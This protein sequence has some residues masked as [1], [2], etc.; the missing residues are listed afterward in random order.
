MTDQPEIPTSPSKTAITQPN[1][2]LLGNTLHW[3]NTPRPA[4][5]LVIKRPGEDTNAHFNKIIEFLYD[6][7]NV[8]L[9]IELNAKDAL[10]ER[11]TNVEVVDTS[12]IASHATW[13]TLQS[14]HLVISLGGDGTILYAASLFQSKN[15]FCP[16][17]LPFALGS[18]GFLTPIKFD[19]YKEAI[20]R[21]LGFGRARS[22]TIEIHE[23]MQKLK[24][25]EY[26]QDSLTENTPEEEEDIWETD[27]G[28]DPDEENNECT[29][30]P[31][32]R[33]PKLSD[34][35]LFS[36]TE[37]IFV[38]KRTRLFARVHCSLKHQKSNSGEL[39]S[40][41][42]MNSLR[43]DDC[44]SENKRFAL[45]E[46]VIDRGPNHGM[47]HLE[48]YINDI[49]I[50]DIRG[51]GL[52]ISTP[53]GSTGYN[54][55]AGGSLV[56]PSTVAVLITPICPHSLSIRPIVIPPGV[57]LVIKVAEDNR[58][59]PWVSFDGRDA[60]ALQKSQQVSIFLPAKVEEQPGFVVPCI[61]LRDPVDDWFGSLSNCLK[62]NISSFSQK[63]LTG[64]GET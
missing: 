53:T 24:I 51:D 49:L 41:D 7:R 50:E 22:H 45:N 9:Y 63:K 56:H 29:V 39:A 2:K 62:W 17:I 54:M 60:H 15:T 26:V 10:G 61:C 34:N 46:I 1:Y 32:M 48:L 55:S 43:N 30:A 4:R 12:K 21:T 16:P 6:K 33:H 28:P 59:D 37:N 57:K 27:N 38:T 3:V 14:I 42:S 19:M 11:F 47:V 52:I 58:T 40:S 31:I 64:N 44:L 8:R 25:K 5:L 36:D 35:S 23:T 13:T 20:S 18:L